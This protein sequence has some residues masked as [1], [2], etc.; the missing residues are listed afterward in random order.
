MMPLLL[1]V[2]AFYLD[3]LQVT[4]KNIP[5]DKFPRIQFYTAEVIKPIVED[6]TRSHKRAELVTYGRLLVR[7]NTTYAPNTFFV[8]SILLLYIYSHES[9]IIRHGKP[10]HEALVCYQRN[11][12][13][14]VTG[15]S[16]MFY[17]SESRCAETGS[18]T[19]DEVKSTNKNIIQY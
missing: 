16:N 5:H 10:R 18:L 4:G 12:A 13:N 11:P 3:N 15:T 8:C 14:N 1:F 19:I 2:Q 6:D 7:T 17:R 9:L